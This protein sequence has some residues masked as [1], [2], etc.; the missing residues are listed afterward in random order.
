MVD[1]SPEI[2]AWVSKFPQDQ[3]P[4]AIEML[5]QLQFISRDTYAEWLKPTLLSISSSVFAVY[6]IRKLDDKIPFL[7]AADGKTLTRPSAS[8]GSEDL[9]HSIVSNLMKADP[10]RILDHPSLQ[11]LR[12]R[13][14][15]DIVLI[16][17]SIGSGDRVNSF[18]RRMMNNPTFLSWWSFGWIRLHIVAFARNVAADR[19]LLESL[20]GS[21]HGL[22]KHPKSS[23][24]R[25]ISYLAYDEKQLSSRWGSN[26]QS[27]LDL[28]DSIKVIPKSRRRGYGQ[29]M[30]NIVFY[31]SVPNNIPGLLWFQN[32]GWNALFPARSVPEWL[33]RLLENSSP[34]RPQSRNALLSDNLISVM[35]WI[36]KG[37]RSKRSLAHSV[38][39]SEEIVDKIL[40]Y[41]RELGLLLQ[42]N[43]LTQAGMQTLWDIKD[44]PPFRE[45]D[46]SLYV[47][48]KWCVGQGTAQPSEP[49][50]EQTDSTRGSPRVDGEAG[51][52]SLERTDAKTAMPS[53]SVTTQ[54]PSVPREGGDAH[55]P[56][57]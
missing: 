41:G 49:D 11:D 57:G 13:K 33:P 24:V 29:I 9:I 25:F 30:A 48:T 2:A 20:P 34:V 56:L 22:R 53:L 18:V 35:R 6:A 23:K 52:T 8:L 26:Y 46:R 55:G 27:T 15:K 14:V 38:G 19:V 3:R 1:V 51:Q 37:L 39:F 44:E 12:K 36:K 17:D 42:G 7:W 28:C 21:E 47:P 31:H 50:R 43:R 45:F 4:T 54:H 5:L 10:T 16:D 40:A 32:E